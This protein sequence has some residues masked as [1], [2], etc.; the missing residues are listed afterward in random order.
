[1]RVSLQPTIS[2]GSVVVA[3]S[4]QASCELSGESVILHLK[5]GIYYGLDRVGTR[6]WSLIQAPTTVGSVRDALLSEYEVD[7]KRCE[8]D[9]LAILQKLADEELVRVVDQQAV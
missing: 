4:D 9:L 6:I 3:T 5:N 1:M 7:S 8:A 2:L